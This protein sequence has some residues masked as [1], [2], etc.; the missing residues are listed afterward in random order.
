MLDRAALEVSTEE[1]RTSM[2]VAMGEDTLESTALI[3][4]EL[5]NAELKDERV[6][7]DP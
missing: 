1:D 2:E 5:G 6:L 4:T 3:E 7:K